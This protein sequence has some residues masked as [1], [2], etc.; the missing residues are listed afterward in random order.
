MSTQQAP[1]HGA[2]RR[3]TSATLTGGALLAALL[4]GVAVAAE[5]LGAETGEGEMTD[6]AAIVDGLVAFTPWAW[7]TAGAYA[8][9]AT[10]VV[11]LIVTAVEYWSVDDRR[12]VLLALAVLAVLTASV[13]VAVLR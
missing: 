13:F 4:F 6:L 7:A 3:Y 9:L 1:Q 10:P 12:T 8:V 2:P 11:G 5:V